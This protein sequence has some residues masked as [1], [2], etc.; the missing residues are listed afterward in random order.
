VGL[1]L[2]SLKHINAY[3]EKRFWCDM[4][5]ESCKYVDAVSWGHGSPGVDNYCTASSRP[6]AAGG[7]ETPSIPLCDSDDCS[8]CSWALKESKLE[9]G[10]NGN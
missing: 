1:L 4:V 10:V 8:K 5:D 6:L 7:Y 9:V 3:K 2:F